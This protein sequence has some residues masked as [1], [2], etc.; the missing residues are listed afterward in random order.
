L[1]AIFLPRVESTS[2]FARIAQNTL[3]QSGGGWSFVGIGIGTAA[4][5]AYLS[6]TRAAGTLILG[7]I[8]IGVAVYYGKSHGSLTLCPIGATQVT[9]ACQTA[10]PG[11]GIYA[12]ASAGCWPRSVAL[13]FGEHQTRRKRSTKLPTNRWMRMEATSRVGFARSR[14]FTRRS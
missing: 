6:H 5:F 14:T 9:A 2:A 3:I 1:I 10:S 7:L 4:W 8:A 13:A 12:Q 11:V